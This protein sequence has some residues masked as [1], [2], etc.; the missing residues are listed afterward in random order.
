MKGKGD[1]Y[2]TMYL[3]FNRDGVPPKMVMDGLA[4][5]QQAPE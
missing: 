1:A 3:F 2:E 4:K 5:I